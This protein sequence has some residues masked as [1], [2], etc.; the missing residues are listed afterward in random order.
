MNGLGETWNRARSNLLGED[1]LGT[2]S[3]WDVGNYFTLFSRVDINH[4]QRTTS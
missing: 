3:D 1:G 4:L 2:G